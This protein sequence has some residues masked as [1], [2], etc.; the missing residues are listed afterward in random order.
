VITL[1]SFLF[2]VNMLTNGI[3]FTAS[4]GR[5]DSLRRLHASAGNC[6]LLPEFVPARFPHHIHIWRLLYN[7]IFCQGICSFLAGP[8]VLYMAGVFNTFTHA[9]L[10][11]ALSDSPLIRSIFRKVQILPPVFTFI[12]IS[13]NLPIRVLMT[14]FYGTTFRLIISE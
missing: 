8:F 4:T 2:Q 3:P 10:F 9:S 1:E 11:I 6:T 14:I 13:L 5:H 7:G 12:I